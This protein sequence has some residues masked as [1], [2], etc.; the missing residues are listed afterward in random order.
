MASLSMAPLTPALTLAN[1]QAVHAGT[2][3]VVVVA[4][5]SGSV[6]S[7]P[8]VL[9]ILVRPD[10]R[11]A[12]LQRDR[13]PGRERHLERGGDQQ[14]HP[15]DWL[16]L[17][18][19]HEQRIAHALVN[20]HVNFLTL[21]NCQATTN[22]EVIVTNLTR[23]VLR[24]SNVV[25]TV[26]ADADGDGLPDA[27]EVDCGLCQTNLNHGLADD[28]ADGRSNLQEYQAGTDPTNALSF[29]QVEGIDRADGGSAVVLRFVAVS[30]LTYTVRYRDV[31]NTGEWT[32]LADVAAAPT[33]RMVE[34]R[35]SAV[36]NGP[37]RFYRLF[38]PGN[39]SP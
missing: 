38:T 1:L 6:T 30:N 13:A 14:R 37:Q 4:D 3:T 21:T 32:R 35:D 12:T 25:V 23:L 20:E 15:A 2:Y 24:S 16:P 17:A 10:H 27:W 8:A 7:A 31:V 9:T 36:P 26:L 11:P 5:P 34:L 28:D 29:L 22:Y 19:G 18:A 39:P 33:N